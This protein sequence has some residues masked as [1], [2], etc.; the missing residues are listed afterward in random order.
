M[1]SS[2]LVIPGSI[3]PFAATLFN[4]ANQ[5]CL[6]NKLSLERGDTLAA[7]RGGFDFAPALLKDKSFV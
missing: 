3:L 5:D 6:K 1:P 4:R 2:G 7:L